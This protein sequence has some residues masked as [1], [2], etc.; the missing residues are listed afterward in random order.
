VTTVAL[1]ILKPALEEPKPAAA[2]RLAAK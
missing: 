2:A 1:L